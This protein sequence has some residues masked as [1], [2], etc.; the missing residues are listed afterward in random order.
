MKECSLSIWAA[1]VRELPVSPTI[2]IDTIS[3]KLTLPTSST[4]G[5]VIV[6][7]DPGVR[8]ANEGAAIAFN[9]H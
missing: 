4:P 1:S 7:D 6:H 3:S 2:T 5:L 9:R 8:P